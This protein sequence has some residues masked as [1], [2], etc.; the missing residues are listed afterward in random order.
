[1]YFSSAKSAGLLSNAELIVFKHGEEQILVTAPD[2]YEVRDRLSWAST[3]LFILLQQ[4][5][6]TI[7]KDEFGIENDSQIILETADVADCGLVNIRPTAWA[8]VLPLLGRVDVKVVER[9]VNDNRALGTPYSTSRWMTR[10]TSRSHIVGP[11]AAGPSN[12]AT[13][14]HKGKSTISSQED[15]PTQLSALKQR[16][17]FGRISASHARTPNK[18]QSS[19]KIAKPKVV[20]VTPQDQKPNGARSSAQPESSTNRKAQKQPARPAVQEQAGEETD[21][22]M[23]EDVEELPVLRSPK[24]SKRQRVDSDFFEEEVH[25]LEEVSVKRRRQSVEETAVIPDILMV[26]AKPSNRKIET[27]KAVD[28]RSSPVPRSKESSS[29]ISKHVLS[30]GAASNGSSSK[31]TLSTLLW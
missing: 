25:I 23:E 21:E 13:I 30:G 19:A 28:R 26:E 1:M 4:G 24:K 2:T 5:A 7:V 18:L 29:D 9:K 17:P 12:A 8:A 16:P 31:G 15:L 14:S 27:L 20:E 22:L 3:Y 10:L 11:N 6:I